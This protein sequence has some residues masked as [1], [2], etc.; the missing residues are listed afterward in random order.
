MNQPDTTAG[1]ERLARLIERIRREE[2]SP[3]ALTRPR[4]HPAPITVEEGLTLLSELGRRRCPHFVIDEE[5]RFTI[6][7]ALRWLLSDD[8]AQALH[9]TTG[10][11]IP[12]D[13]SRGLYLSGLTGTGKTLLVQL[14]RD[15]SDLLG[16]SVTL[17]D[18]ERMEWRAMPLL[19][20]TEEA[21]AIADH[22]TTGGDLKGYKARPILCINDLGREQAEALYMGN[23]LRVCDA[24]IEHRGDKAGGLMLITSNLRLGG[25]RFR[26][27][28]G[29]RVQSRLVEQ[30]NVLE[31]MGAD[32]R[33]R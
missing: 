21:D 18:P 28:Y 29:D 3:Q 11:I 13:L 17:Y 8:G 7:H 33:R 32:R 1:S 12:A 22:Y 16:L 26:E 31:L 2:D 25:G 30:C 24:I 20:R 27:R 6:E 10:A 9:P 19:W 14:L 23:R 15:L 5:N 4:R